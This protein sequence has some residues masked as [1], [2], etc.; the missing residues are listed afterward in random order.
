[1]CRNHCTNSHRKYA[2]IIAYVG[3]IGNSSLEVVACAID[4]TG[5]LSSLETVSAGPMSTEDHASYAIDPTGKN[6][7]ILK[8]EAKNIYHYRIDPLTGLFAGSPEIIAASDIPVSISFHPSGQM[9]YVLTSAAYVLNPAG[10]NLYSID[11]SSQAMTFVKKIDIK[12]APS[13]TE[14]RTLPRDIIVDPSGKFVY[15]L[16]DSYDLLAPTPGKIFVYAIDATGDLTKINET[17]TT[18]YPQAMVL[19]GK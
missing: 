15:A 3:S 18:D 2:Y 6:F 4:N 1:M 11:P 5:L 10:I 16:L 13:I 19:W 8:R 17:S 7:F 12:Y 14:I 9:A